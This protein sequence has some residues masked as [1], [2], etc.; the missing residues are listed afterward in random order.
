MNSQHISKLNE[1]ILWLYQDE[2]S[3][4]LEKII[5]QWQLESHIKNDKNEDV[6]IVNNIVLEKKLMM[7]KDKVKGFL[8]EGNYVFHAEDFDGQVWIS[9]SDYNYF[10]K[11]GY[12]SDWHLNFLVFPDFLHE[13]TEGGFSSEK[14]IDTTIKALLKLGYIEDPNYSSLISSHL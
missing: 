10:K 14:D 7:I 5:D 6:F 12:S 11:S 2:E 1:W 13:E 8:P 9:V 4:F 3:D